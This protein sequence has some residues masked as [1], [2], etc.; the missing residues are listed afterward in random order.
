MKTQI[1]KTAFE[2]AFKTTNLIYAMETA[3]IIVFIL[4]LPCHNL[5]A[6]YQNRQISSCTFN[7]GYFLGF[8][9]LWIR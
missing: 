7:D 6:F 1:S 5:R 3:I 2:I 8:N 4:G 9:S